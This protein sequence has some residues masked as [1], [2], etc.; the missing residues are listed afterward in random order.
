MNAKSETYVVKK[1]DKVSAIAKTFGFSDW[2]VIWNDKANDGLRKSRGK[3]ESI[4][5]GDK[6]V[7][8]PDPQVG[9]ESEEQLRKLQSA[10]ERTRK[11]RVDSEKSFREMETQLEGEFEDM[12]DLSDKV[13]LAALIA[14]AFVGAATEGATILKGVQATE[15][16]TVGAAVKGG[17]KVAALEIVVGIAQPSW[18]ANQIVKKITGQDNKTAFKTARDQLRSVASQS[19]KNID[20]RIGDLERRI[21]DASR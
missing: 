9:K 17:L 14:T 8:P 15:Q 16:A 20:V 19:L 1:G 7:I 12:E 21:K 10:L 6:L 11:L 4:E 2:K 5:A 3:P 13:D 18:W